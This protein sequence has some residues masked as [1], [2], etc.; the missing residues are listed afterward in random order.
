RNLLQGEG[1]I[2]KS[3]LMK[4][5]Q[6]HIRNRS[7]QQRVVGELARLASGSGSIN[8]NLLEM[9]VSDPAN[10]VEVDGRFLSAVEIEAMSDRVNPSLYLAEPEAFYYGLRQLDNNN[11]QREFYITDLVKHLPR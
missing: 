5:V 6:R 2:L 8:R 7:K 4:I 1:E 11:E 3:D 10:Q 9:F